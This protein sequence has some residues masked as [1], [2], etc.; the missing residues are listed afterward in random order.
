MQRGQ[1]DRGDITECLAALVA[2]LELLVLLRAEGKNGVGHLHLRNSIMQ[3][4]QVVVS[5]AQ[6]KLKYKHKK[7]VPASPQRWPQ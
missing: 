6:H 4:T 5:K 2:V 3:S 7:T 1:V